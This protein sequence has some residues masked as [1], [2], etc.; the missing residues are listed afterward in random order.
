MVALFGIGKVAEIFPHVADS[1]DLS[2]MSL[3]GI[4]EPNRDF[5]INLH[6]FPPLVFS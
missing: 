3:V 2:S 6:L 4:D 5:V 1:I